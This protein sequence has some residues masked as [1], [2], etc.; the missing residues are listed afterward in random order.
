MVESAD[1]RGTASR[2][3]VRRYR[4]DDR[5]AVLSLYESAGT[6]HSP[7]WFA[8]RFEHNPFSSRVPVLVAV[9]PDGDLAGALPLAALRLGLGTPR[10][11]VLG[12]RVGDPLVRRCHDRH[13]VTTGLATACAD[14]Y[15]GEDPAV[16]FRFAEPTADSRWLDPDARTAGAVRTHYRVQ[17]PAVLSDESRRGRLARAV[18]P[19]VAGYLEVRDRL[20][21]VPDD[22]TVH[23]YTDLPLDLLWSLYR[24]AVP[25]TIH[26]IRNP[27]YYRWRFSDPEALATTYVT[28]LGGEPAAAVV[29]YADARDGVR[30]LVLADLVPLLPT[31][32]R[33]AATKAALAVIVEE[34]DDADLLVASGSGFPPAALR[35]FG[36]HADDAL[37]LSAVTTPTT[38]VVAPLAGRSSSGRDRWTLGGRALDDVT[39][40]TVAFG[41]REAG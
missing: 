20:V 3:A 18:S 25:N 27:A 5:A 37:P 24:R 35:A 39:N 9:G 30:R 17:R 4:E 36:F 33:T 23:R 32:D 16:R 19:A 34:Y 10:E 6:P 13:E 14:R 28:T 1:R 31:P 41:L 7:E 11:A 21:T 2:Y 40:W 12:L 15:A 26:A 29:A 38:L 22:V 8:W